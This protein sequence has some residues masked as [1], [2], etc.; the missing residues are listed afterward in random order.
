MFSYIS[1]AH[2]YTDSSVARASISSYDNPHAPYAPHYRSR[3]DIAMNEHVHDGLID[4]YY[5]D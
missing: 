1:A 2:G 4:P 3:S 5:R